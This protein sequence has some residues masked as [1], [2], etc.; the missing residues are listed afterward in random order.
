MDAYRSDAIVEQIVKTLHA[1]DL[2]HIQVRV[3]AETGELVPLSGL[4]PAAPAIAPTTPTNDEVLPDRLW[5]EPDRTGMEPEYTGQ[6]P[7]H[8]QGQPQ[9]PLSGK[10]VW[11]SA[12]HGW[13][14]STTLSSWRSQRPNTYGII[15]DFANAEAVNY[16]LA[17]YLWNAGADVWLVRERAMT[18]H[19]VIVDNDSGAPA[20]TE[21]GSWTTSS[22]PG[23]NEGTYRWASTFDD[24]ATA[25]ATWTPNLPEAGRYAVWA[26]YRE[27]ANRAFD[28]RFEVHHAGGITTVSTSQEVHGRTWRY[29]GEYYFEAGASG[30][31]TLINQSDDPAQVV[32]ADAIRFGGGLGSIPEPGGTSGEP[33]WEEAS[34]YWV[35]YQ[36]EEYRRPAR[37]L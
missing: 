26:W 7:V 1:L 28:A 13:Y 6:P 20:Y 18:E 12:G 8:G 33:R 11:L 31:V 19:E 29:L 24:A 25:A 30:Y 4:L 37:H 2:H 16:Y 9:G 21:T 27:G 10:T 5:P 22:T 15:E 23:Y 34:K 17:R 35:Q 32:V 3:L 14:W 36:V